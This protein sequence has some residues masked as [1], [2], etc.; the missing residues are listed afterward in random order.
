[1][2]AVVFKS[3][4]P[5]VEQSYGLNLYKNPLTAWFKK[6]FYRQN[7]YRI[8]QGGSAVVEE[9]FIDKL[10][11]Y[12]NYDKYVFLCQ[13]NYDI[14]RNTDQISNYKNGSRVEFVLYEN[15]YKLNY[16][17][18]I[19]HGAYTAVDEMI[20][21][22]K[23]PQKLFWPSHGITHALSPIDM[24]IPTGLRILIE[25]EEYDCIT[26]TSI[27]G[28][29]ALESIFSQFSDYLAHHLKA[30][31]A[32]RGQFGLI[33]LAIDT[34]YY[35]PRDKCQARKHFNL[36]RDTTIFLCLG[37]FSISLKMD[38]FPLLNHFLEKISNSDKK[39]IL[40]FA[41]SEDFVEETLPQTVTK[42]IE[43]I[44]RKSGCSQ[45]IRVFHN[46]KKEDKALLYSAADVFVSPS[47]N[48]QE[49][50]G[51]TI[52]EAMASGLPVIASD[53]NG[54]RE[55]IKHGETGFLVPT[56]WTD[57]IEHT[58]QFSRLYGH[59]LTHL[60]LSQSVC[61]D[62]KK[63]IEYMDILYENPDLRKQMSN[64]ARAY[65]T[66][67]YDW[68][69]IIPKYEELWEELLEIADKKQSYDGAI[70]NHG[71]SSLDFLN[72]FGHY[73]SRMIRGDDLLKIT[74]MGY[75]FI[76]NLI[77]I[78]PLE[79]MN[80]YSVGT[81]LNQVIFKIICN[82]QSIKLCDLIQKI[83]TKSTATN[84]VII[85]YIMRLI[86]YGILEIIETV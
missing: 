62:T 22:R 25:S 34:S 67:H 68:S 78:Y 56:C 86:K 83:N 46:L 66:N 51:I 38:I 37:R 39:A 43:L 16:H 63:I 53:W 54:Y 5:Q 29:K 20:H 85:H 3:L 27:A 1:M 13:N 41:G 81:E 14:E 80:T 40:I 70:L 64:N 50:F 33:P 19:L 76:N 26:C 24:V 65:I 60:L 12:G 23:I 47:D 71:L 52:L 45:Y 2:K 30:K 31:V 36:T 42:T 44:A 82:C 7:Q 35:Y 10:L 9:E 74:S 32:Y 55:T 72:I 59:K 75:K 6:I 48:V 84:H 61:V 28:K 11:E 57:S 18:A 69:C 4:H 77:E 8:L 73:P 15:L 49:T 79:V 21:L 58:S 17:K